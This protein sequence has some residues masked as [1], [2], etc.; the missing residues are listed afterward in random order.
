MYQSSTLGRNLQMDRTELKILN[1]PYVKSLKVT[2]TSM[3]FLRF[4]LRGRG[5]WRRTPDMFADV[6][7]SLFGG[8]VGRVRCRF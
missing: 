7:S 6:T 1:K 3:L 2:L 5:E 8:I 4:F